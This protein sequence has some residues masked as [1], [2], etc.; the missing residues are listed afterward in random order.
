MWVFIAIMAIVVVAIIGYGLF[1]RKKEADTQRADAN[2]KA[3]AKLNIHPRDAVVGDILTIED[4]GPNHLDVTFPIRGLHTYVDE[5]DFRWGEAYGDGPTGTIFAEFIEDDD[6]EIF[7]KLGKMDIKLGDIGITEDDLWK[8][9]DEEE[10]FVEYDGEK[11]EYEDSGEVTFYKDGEGNGEKFYSWDFRSEDGL[12]S[13]SFEKYGS[14]KV[15]AGICNKVDY[16]QIE[17]T[18]P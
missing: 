2:E 1:L 8:I 7:V 9:D 6:I 10:G 16:R 18:R 17:L 13:L 3:A 11:F 12:L 4:V 5:D 15:S 14:D